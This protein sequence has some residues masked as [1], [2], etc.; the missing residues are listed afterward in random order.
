MILSTFT[1]DV[2]EFRVWVQQLLHL[3]RPA[4]VPGLRFDDGFNVGDSNAPVDDRVTFNCE[5]DV[6]RAGSDD[7]LVG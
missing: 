5:S 6:P 3:H 4:F 7:S 2:S 1:P